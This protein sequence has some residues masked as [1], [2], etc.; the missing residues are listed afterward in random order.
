MTISVLA[1]Q[2]HKRVVTSNDTVSDQ[3]ALPNTRFETGEGNEFKRVALPV[4]AP[5]AATSG[6][7]NGGNGN[8]N[9]NGS[10]DE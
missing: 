5:V 7:S 6:E 8:G 3:A 10:G 9:G 4:S 2:N 1:L